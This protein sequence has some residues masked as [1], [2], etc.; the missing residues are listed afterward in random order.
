[1]VTWAGMKGPNGNMVCLKHRNGL[2]SCYCHLS[3]YG[4]G[5]KAGVHVEQ[6][7]VIGYVG[8]TGLSTGPHLHYAL[9]RNGSFINPLTLKL[10][11]AEPIPANL[12]D[13]FHHQIQPIVDQLVGHSVAAR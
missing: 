2:E 9:K 11:P 6:K 3:A 5:V 12:A 10:P 13:D 1:M 8:T 4:D 7:K